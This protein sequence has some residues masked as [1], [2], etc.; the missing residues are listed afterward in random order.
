[1]RSAASA[2]YLESGKRVTTSLKAAND[3]RVDFG[4]RSL[5]SG[6]ARCDSMP[7]WSLKLISPFRY[8]A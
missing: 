6:V 7:C 5:M 1:M 3:S 4:S 8:Q 2:A